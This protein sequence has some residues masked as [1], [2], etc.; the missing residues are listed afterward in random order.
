M[1][2][3]L[4]R[5]F[6]AEPVTERIQEAERERRTLRDRSWPAGELAHRE[7]TQMPLEEKRAR[8]HHVITNHGDLNELEAA[9]RRLV[10]KLE[11]N[12]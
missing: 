3:V 1:T 9:I 2:R 10:A 8:A 7:A 12:A 6:Q 11:R 4:T 5:P